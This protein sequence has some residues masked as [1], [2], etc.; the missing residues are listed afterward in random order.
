[1]K[2]TILLIL[3]LPL[4]ASQIWLVV[5]AFK[6]SGLLWAVLIAF[7]SFIAGFAF[8]L[9]KKEGWLP[10]GINL[11]TSVAVFLIYRYWV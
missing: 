1:M 9:R 4:L 3:L 10:W 11:I 2:Q 7:F 6:R 8:C 5:L